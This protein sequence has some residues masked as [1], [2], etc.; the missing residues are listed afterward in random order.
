VCFRICPQGAVQGEKKEP[1][2]IDQKKCVKCSACYE[3]C[4]FGA[5]MIK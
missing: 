4:K 2:R 3:S 1:H 5:I